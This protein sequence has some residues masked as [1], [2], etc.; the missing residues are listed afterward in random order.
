MFFRK[1]RRI[2]GTG[3]TMA[4]L[5]LQA[6][7]LALAFVLIGSVAYYS[8][9]VED[10]LRTRNSQL[11][12]EVAAL[13]GEVSALQTR[14]AELQSSFSLN[15]TST[16]ASLLLTSA[17]EANDAQ[18]IS[19]IQTM[20]QEYQLQL[21][22]LGSE[23]SA[24]DTGSSNALNSISFQLQ[25]ITEGIRN[26]N[27][28]LN[29]IP[30][31]VLLRTTGTAL[32]AFVQ[33][34]DNLT[35]LRLLEIGNASC[36]ESS[37]AS[38]PFNATMAGAMVQW[39]AVA[40]DVATDSYHAFWP[41]VLENTPGGT[42]ALEFEDYGGFEEVAVVS[43]GE[44]SAIPV[45]WNATAANTFAIEIVSPGHRANFFI[46]GVSV[47]NFT[48]GVPMVGFLLEGA[49]VRGLGSS[50]PLVATLDAYGGL[51]GGG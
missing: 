34:S 2:P 23:I 24:L 47:A 49:E 43:N 18:Q 28:N 9:T 27:D 29:S 12:S 25:N 38:H 21:S 22:N 4:Q 40:N 1:L 15:L 17:A 39:R 19:G 26:L 16:Q 11:D 30:P 44:R 7:G 6:I 48:S 5:R 37:L 32:G 20:L 10:Q 42:N 50:F 51:L 14:M 45:Y 35:Y 41:M 46:N 33:G 36:V 31:S 8:Y 13:E 3:K